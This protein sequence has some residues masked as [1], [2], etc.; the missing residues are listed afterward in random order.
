MASTNHMP[1]VWTI[2][3]LTDNC[4]NHPNTTPLFPSII[5]DNALKLHRGMLEFLTQKQNPL[6]DRA[7][8]YIHI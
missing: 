2:H 7:T 8:K 6:K 1:K 4:S 3:V 5:G